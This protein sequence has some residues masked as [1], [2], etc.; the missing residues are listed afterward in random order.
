MLIEANALPLIQTTNHFLQVFL[1]PP[2]GIQMCG[3]QRLDKYLNTG[4]R[5][6]LGLGDANI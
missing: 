3:I 4:L 1:G 6:T 2:L 5:D